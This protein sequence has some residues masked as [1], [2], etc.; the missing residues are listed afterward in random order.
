MKENELYLV[1]EKKIDYPLITEMDSML[2]ICFKYCHIK[3]FH[4]FKHECI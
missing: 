3:N 1:K 2:D 4:N